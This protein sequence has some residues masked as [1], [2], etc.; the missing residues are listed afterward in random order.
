MV[1]RP[2]VHQPEHRRCGTVLQLDQRKPGDDVEVCRPGP[3]DVDLGATAAWGDRSDA[4]D[5]VTAEAEV[6]HGVVQARL[7]DVQQVVAQHTG[8]DQRPGDLC[9]HDGEHG[10]GIVQ[11]RVDCEALRG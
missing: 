6:R 10:G 9:I 8:A 2:T 11:F 5:A 1:S 7:G 3:A 4:V